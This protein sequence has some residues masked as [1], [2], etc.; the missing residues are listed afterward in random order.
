MK[1]YK[2]SDVFV[3]FR[4]MYFFIRYI[5]TLYYIYIYTLYNPHFFFAIYPLKFVIYFRPFFV[6]FWKVSPPHR[7]R[8]C[9]HNHRRRLCWRWPDTFRFRLYPT[10]DFPT[11]RFPL[12]RHQRSEV[13]MFRCPRFPIFFYIFVLERGQPDVCGNLGLGIQSV[14]AAGSVLFDFF[15]GRRFVFGLDSLS[16]SCP[17]VSGGFREL[18]SESYSNWQRFLFR[19]RFQIRF[20]LLTVYLLPALGRF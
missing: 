4:D 5:F 14:T 17:T 2:I 10:Y 13:P 3:F 20:R 16:P 7:M 11:F 12:P 6:F 1:K 8:R 15:E 18:W 19:F 9:H